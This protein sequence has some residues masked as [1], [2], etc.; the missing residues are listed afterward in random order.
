LATDTGTTHYGK[1]KEIQSSAEVRGDEGNTVLIK[2]ELD[3]KEM[4]ILREHQ[5]LRPGATVTA[6]VNC[7]PCCLGYKLLHD[8]GAFIQ[9]RIFFKFF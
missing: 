6:K 4:E 1:V 7:G 2:V 9:S 8:V 3:E 5:Q